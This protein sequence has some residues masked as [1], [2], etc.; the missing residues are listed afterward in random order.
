MIIYH[1]SYKEIFL[2]AF[3]D[4]KITNYFLYS[5]PKERD[6]IYDIVMENLGSAATLY[7]DN[8]ACIQGRIA[9]VDPVEEIVQLERPFQ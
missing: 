4:Q 1:Y 2:F 3:I 7:C 9:Y 5:V 6:S 8:G